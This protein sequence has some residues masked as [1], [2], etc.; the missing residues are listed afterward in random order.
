[1]Y[2]EKGGQSGEKEAYILDVSC[3]RCG[4]VWIHEANSSKRDYRGTRGIRGELK[5]QHRQ[6][7]GR[8]G[9]G[10]GR[11]D[12][13]GGFVCRDRRA[14]VDRTGREH[15]QGIRKRRASDRES[16]QRES[17]REDSHSRAA[18]TSN[19]LGGNGGESSREASDGTAS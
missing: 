7:G 18:Q 1:M 10:G 12:W 2:R 8:H 6:W 11:D 15:S 9:A 16:E 14:P 13:G 17:R 19:V 5:T 3:W 4:E